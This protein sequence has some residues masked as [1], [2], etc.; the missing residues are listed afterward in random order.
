M[1]DTT[2]CFIFL[3]DP[4]F[5]IIFLRILCEYALDFRPLLYCLHCIKVKSSKF[6]QY[7]NCNT[8]YTRE[9]TFFSIS[10]YYLAIL[11]LKLLTA[12]KHL[13]YHIF[14]ALPTQILRE[15][16]SSDRS[17]VFSS[18]SQRFSGRDR[19]DT[20]YLYYYVSAER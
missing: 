4:T 1:W 6:N 15:T 8:L 16:D 14:Y 11:L 18:S 10:N 7:T 3:W 5:A 13:L 2:F 9:S 12:I 17:L 20:W 19:S